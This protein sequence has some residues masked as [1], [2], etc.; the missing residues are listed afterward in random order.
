MHVSVQIMSAGKSL[1]LV[2]SVSA[3]SV[4]SALLIACTVCSELLKG[5]LTAPF[6]GTTKQCKTA[7]ARTTVLV[8]GSSHM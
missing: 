7:A 6:Q 5:L 3:V 2:H 4:V 1:A 8:T